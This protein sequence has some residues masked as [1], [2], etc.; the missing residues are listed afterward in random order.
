MKSKIEAEVGVQK[1]IS[2]CYA[3]TS[4]LIFLGNRTP[5]TMASMSSDSGISA[6]SGSTAYVSPGPPSIATSTQKPTGNSFISPTYT[7]FP[8]FYTLQPNLTTRARQLELWS[9]L[10]TS[11]C[12][13][14]N[15]FRISLSS[16]PADLFANN[17]INRS[18]RP[19]DIKTVLDHM[20]KPENG[21]QVE[22]I[23]PTSKS[24]QSNS[25]YVW[26]RTAGDWADLLYAWVEETGQKGTVLTLYEL[27]EGD[28]VRVK[29]WKLMDEG[30]LRK[31]L[32]VIVKR[33]KAQVFGQEAGGEG[34]KFF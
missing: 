33:G 15:I 16:P 23:P 30:M 21:G 3:A 12:R 8:P 9:S 32:N 5:Q 24:E 25:C 10:I 2:L 17:D 4:H 11:S 7:S 27:R 31:V 22:W 20:N 19:A 1:V 28:A 26:W 34:V 29:E 14:H 18:L 13:Q 6:Y